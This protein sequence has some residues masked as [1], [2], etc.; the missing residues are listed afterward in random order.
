MLRERC[1]GRRHYYERTTLINV[2]IRFWFLTRARV[3]FADQ[4][5]N[6]LS[7]VHFVH[8]LAR[9]HLYIVGHAVADGHVICKVWLER[10]RI[11]NEVMEMYIY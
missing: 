10:N 5:N 8:T 7:A 9:L 3:A 6:R 4:H 11:M 2:K 1:F